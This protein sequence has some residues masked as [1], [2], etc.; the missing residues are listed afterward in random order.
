MASR[1]DLINELGDAAETMG[2][3]VPTVAKRATAERALALRL[4]RTIVR[5][6]ACVTADARKYAFVND[7][8][9]AKDMAA[10][11]SAWIVTKE[12]EL[13]FMREE[14]AQLTEN[15]K[16]LQQRHKDLEQRA[17]TAR[18][19]L[20]Q[21][22]QRAETMQQALAEARTMATTAPRSGGRK[23]ATT[24]P[25][26]GG[27]SAE[28]STAGC[29]PS[30]PWARFVLARPWF[31]KRLERARAARLARLVKTCA[32]DHK[33]AQ[34]GAATA[35]ATL[36]AAKEALAVSLEATEAQSI[37]LAAAAAQEAALLRE[38]QRP[39]ALLR[40]A[41]ARVHILHHIATA[42]QA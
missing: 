10:E 27:R 31:R 14:T 6:Y 5:D 24:S 36:A 25:R 35:K 41:Q 17:K 32:R 7:L 15:L 40:D 20:W 19:A 18:S 42:P 2:Y 16:A 26:S 38:T 34:K 37:S 22:Q 4:P 13:S 11:L 12:E 9:T 8:A 39:R 3:V 30:S 1:A 29:A 33:A 28:A 23:M 21:E